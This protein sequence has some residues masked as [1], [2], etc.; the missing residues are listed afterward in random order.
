V[1]VGQAF[2]VEV[3]T[4]TN[5]NTLPWE[6]YQVSLDYND[7][8]F[9]GIPAATGGWVTTP[10]EGTR[11]A[12]MFT[13][14]T[15]AFCTP[16]TQTAS[17][18]NEDDLGLAQWAV[19]CTED[20]PATDHP[21]EGALIQFTFLC[22]TAGQANFD[23]RDVA[24]TFLFDSQ[25]AAY[26]DHVHNAQV[27][28]VAPTNTPGGATDTPVAPTDTPAVP[29]DTP[30]APTDTPAVPTNT[31]GGPTDTP[32][33]PTNTPP[34]PTDTPVAPTDTPVA[35]TNTPGAP[36]DT[37]VAPTNTPPAPTNTPGGPTD[38]PV[39]ATNTP[40]GPTNTPGPATNTP[41]PQVSA[42]APSRDE[43]EDD[44][45]PTR[46]ATPD[47]TGTAAV[48]T[49][50]TAPTTG[51]PPAVNTATS[52]AGGAGAG[53]VQPPDT[54]TGPGGSTGSSATS[55]ALLLSGVGL[56]AIAGTLVGTRLRRG[57]R[58]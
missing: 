23:L 42:T 49:P 18:F 53:G 22:E 35:P 40:V 50:G 4:N 43:S 1:S 17:R 19:T 34:A 15:G 41:G 33:P 51:V 26:G 45:T 20:V 21:G 11:G 13:F 32:A 12:N 14:T 46:T 9:D 55:V 31:P 37:P 56:L 30:A 58:S 36:T 24:D 3:S 29:T 2:N 39:A 27:D 10:I 44:E 7:V 54:G 47:S 28:C 6:A 25:G 5:P 52:P 57:V 16:A 38:T 48:E 8:A